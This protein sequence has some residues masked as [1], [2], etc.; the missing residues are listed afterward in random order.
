MSIELAEEG[1]S[2]L[3]ATTDAV[4]TALAELTT[5]NTTLTELA[6]R[7]REIAAKYDRV[8]F[9]VR[10]TKGMEAAKQARLEFRDQVRYPMQ[11]LRDGGKKLLNTMKAQF[12]NRADALIEEVQMHESQIDEQIT[13]EEQRKANEKAEREAA[14]QRRKAAI[15]ESI[16]AIQ[17]AALDAIGESG[18]E[19]EARLVGVQ[20]IIIDDSYDEFQGQA[21]QAKDEALHK[22]NGLL[23]SARAEESDQRE[24]EEQR[25][26]QA[27]LDERQ[28]QEREALEA[29]AAELERREREIADREAEQ[30]R[31]AEQQ[32][33]DRQEAER[34]A[35]ERTAQIAKTIQRNID[36]IRAPL[37]SL[38]ADATTKEIGE[39]IQKMEAAPGLLFED[40]GE[41]LSEAMSVRTATLG[42]LRAFHVAAAERERMAWREQ[43]IRTLQEIIDDVDHYDQ[44]EVDSGKTIVPGLTLDEET[45]GDQLYAAC[46][47]CEE[48]ERKLALRAGVLAQQ[49]AEAEERDRQER[50][51]RE[52][53]Q[54]ELEAAQNRMAGALAMWTALHRLVNGDHITPQEERE[55][56]I[57]LLE[58][59]DG[60]KEP[61]S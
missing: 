1:G 11:R 19:I 38:G 54:R 20:G 40:F 37:E 14:E 29:R 32:E 16:Q 28:R 12:E 53:E 17:S 33:R 2:T 25:Q 5:S 4:T 49:R 44:I 51:A 60:R 34:R 47:L 7:G 21:Q 50:E 24:L 22:L 42:A 45:F 23:V 35:Q 58:A 26:R 9:D 15:V 27:A 39:L 41:R 31:V 18:D 48:L 52:A 3:P 36:A 46:T 55:R 43:A 30:R 61:Q 8:V 59:I 6:E 13:A 10:T 57:E 56:V